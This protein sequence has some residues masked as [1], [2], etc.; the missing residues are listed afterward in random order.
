MIDFRFQLFGFNNSLWRP[1]T[2]RKLTRF[3]SGCC[4]FFCLFLSLFCQVKLGSS[5]KLENEVD[6]IEVEKEKIRDTACPPR[7]TIVTVTAYV[8]AS[9]VVL[10]SSSISKEKKKKKNHH[11]RTRNITV[12]S[13]SFFFFFFD[14]LP[15]FVS[16]SFI[17]SSSSPFRDIRLSL[18]FFFSLFISHGTPRNSIS[19]IIY[20]FK[21]TI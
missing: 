4:F 5:E 10:R 12:F 7:S 3:F 15:F 9:A 14:P 11:L 8:P 1:K 2:E 16:Q 17:F 20:I 13:A 6:V 19:L 21:Y 18:Y